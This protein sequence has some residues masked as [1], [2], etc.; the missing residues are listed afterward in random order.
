MFGVPWCTLVRRHL[1]TSGPYL[2]LI[3]L[4]LVLEPRELGLPRQTMLAFWRWQYG[5]IGKAREK[6]GVTLSLSLKIISTN[7]LLHLRH[8]ITLSSPTFRHKVRVSLFVSGVTFSLQL[9]ICD[10]PWWPLIFVSTS[11]HG[12]VKYWCLERYKERFVPSPMLLFWQSQALYYTKRWQLFNWLSST[13]HYLTAVL[14]NK[15]SSTLYHLVCLL[16]HADSQTS[17]SILYAKLKSALLHLANIDF[18][19]L[20]P[21]SLAPNTA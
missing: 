15:R 20:C 11:F 13:K 5:N 14:Y 1:Q 2:V 21:L 12:G 7:V 9:P 19:L 4:E 8:P 18:L 17:S 10:S 3:R 6:Q 16:P